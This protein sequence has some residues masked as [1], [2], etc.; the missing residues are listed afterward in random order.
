LPNC[1]ETDEPLRK[2][3]M[4]ALE[5]C[6]LDGGADGGGLHGAEM[7]ARVA[8]HARVSP[9]GSPCASPRQLATNARRAAAAQAAESAACCRYRQLHP[10]ETGLKTACEP[11]ATA[12]VIMR[13]S[14]DR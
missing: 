11:D 9:D 13:D 8:R 6:G 10:P 3:L 5:V 2:P 1:W 14:C 4:E 7:G 12:T